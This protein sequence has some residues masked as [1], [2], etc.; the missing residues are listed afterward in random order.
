MARAT[1]RILPAGRRL[2]AFAVSNKLCFVCFTKRAKQDQS[3]SDCF[4]VDQLAAGFLKLGL[5]KGD[6]VGIWG[7]S[8]IEWVL[9]QFA[10]ARLGIILVRMYYL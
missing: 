3:D 7:P 5:K 4:Q 6:R 1:F 10:T 9:T 2:H 8:S